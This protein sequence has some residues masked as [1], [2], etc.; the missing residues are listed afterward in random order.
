ME[1][2]FLEYFIKMLIDCD[3]WQRLRTTGLGSALEPEI[4]DKVGSLKQFFTLSY[5]NGVVK[6][7][8]ESMGYSIKDA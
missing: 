8:E 4:L 2:K 3:A 7:K 5:G 1:T 6:D